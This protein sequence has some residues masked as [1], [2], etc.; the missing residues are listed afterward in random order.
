M[1]NREKIALALSVSVDPY[2][3]V[4]IIGYGLLV[5]GIRSSV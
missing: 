2:N 3:Y 5:I 1:L 4:N